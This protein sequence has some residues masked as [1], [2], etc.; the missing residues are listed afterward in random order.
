MSYPIA[1]GHRTADY[2]PLIVEL[3]LGDWSVWR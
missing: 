3:R 2:D 1:G